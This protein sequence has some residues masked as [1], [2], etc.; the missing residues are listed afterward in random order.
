ME[1]ASHPYNSSWAWAQNCI[2]VYFFFN[3]AELYALSYQVVLIIAS[4]KSRR[5]N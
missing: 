2:C 1:G 4:E 5:K 3:H